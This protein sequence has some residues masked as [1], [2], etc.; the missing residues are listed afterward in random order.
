[1]LPRI[2]GLL[3]GQR[4]AYE[5]LSGTIERFPSGAEMNALLCANGFAT[6]A[7]TPLSGG[8]ASLYTARK[9]AQA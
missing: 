4:Q 8:I 2:A 5:Y 9:K 3:T 7:D 1:M 6:A